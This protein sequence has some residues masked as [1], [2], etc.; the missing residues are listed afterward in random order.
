MSLIAKEKLQ[1]HTSFRQ[2][3]LLSP[4]LFKVHETSLEPIHC[5]DVLL[6]QALLGLW[7]HN[8]SWFSAVMPVDISFTLLLSPAMN[9]SNAT[10][11]AL[12]QSTSV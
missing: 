8:F 6:H 2:S 9:Y 3:S 10:Y 11:L 5:L 4:N 7:N 12:A 1:I